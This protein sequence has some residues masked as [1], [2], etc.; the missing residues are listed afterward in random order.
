MNNIIHDMTWHYG[1]DEAAGNF[2]NTNQSVQGN[3]GDEVQAEAQDGGGTNNANF[4][5]PPDGGNGRMQ[6][7]LW[8]NSSNNLL[9]GISPL[10]IIGGYNTGTAAFGPQIDENF[11]AIEG[12]LVDAFDATGNPAQACETIINEEEVKGKIALIDRGVCFFQEKALRA[13]EAGAIAVIICNFEENTIN[14]AEGA[15]LDQPTIPTLMLKNSDCVRLRQFI[16]QPAVVRIELP[17]MSGPTLLDGDFDN[18]IIAHEYGHGIS[19]RLTGGPAQAGCLGNDEQMGEGWSDYFSL[20]TT[21]EPG[22]QGTDPRGIGNFAI[23]EQVTGGGIRR[24]P[25]STDESIND[26]TYDDIIGTGAPHPLGEIWAGVTWDLYWALVDQYGYDPDIYNGNG[27]N[28]IAIQL[29]MDG[30]KLQNCSP[31]LVDGRDG[32]LAA[33]QANYGGANECLIWDVFARRGLGFSADQGFSSDRNDNREAFDPRPQC[34]KELKITKSSTSNVNPG[35]SFQVVLEVRNDKEEDVTDVVVLDELPEGLTYESFV[36]PGGV[37]AALVNG[38]NDIQFNIGDLATGESVI[39][40]YTVTAAEEFR[41]AL[42]SF[43]GAEEDGSSTHTWTFNTDEGNAFWSAVDTNAFSGERAYFV[44]NVEG[45]NDQRLITLFPIELPVGNPVL[46]FQHSYDTEVGFDGGIVQISTDGLNWTTLENDEI[47]R[48]PYRGGLAYG[49]FAI[50]NLNAFWGDSD[51]YVATYIDLTEWAGE[52]AFLRFR[53]GSD[54]QGA[55]F[56]WYVDDIE[57]IDMFNY[58]SQACVSSAEGDNAC[59]TAVERGTVVEPS[60]VV[61]TDDPLPAGQVSIF[62]NPA[63]D[64]LQ[65]AYEGDGGER[66]QVRLVSM[67][68]RVVSQVEREAISGRQIVNVDVNQLP[69]GLYLVHVQTPMG[70]HTE[71]VS[72]Q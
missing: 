61:N 48:N 51:G 30:M 71:K 50:P 54:E 10:E 64:Q 34:I 35:A 63:D 43:E 3:A 5:T 72:I 49:T 47:F 62:P 4:A 21:V 28:N 36:A 44:P 52:N 12:E 6:M 24:L 59:V 65:V 31:G 27:G 9:T 37:T 57:I 14:M 2:Q 70:M 53:F 45:N 22:D 39:I 29:V 68:G 26:Q 69:A 18:G 55:G 32:I 25:Y 13:D 33:D 8:T 20:I 60:G 19:N 16:D 40:F 23:G 41:S 11:V 7:F 1:F 67:D 38:G 66:L 58:N 56:G 46:R 42:A 15:G 17:D